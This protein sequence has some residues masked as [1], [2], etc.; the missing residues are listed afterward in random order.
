MK[1]EEKANRVREKPI[2]MQRKT[3]AQLSSS[4]NLLHKRAANKKDILR[5]YSPILVPTHEQY[6]GTKL[7]CEIVQNTE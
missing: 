2:R 7:S 1:N 5:V 6:D 4:I 3:N